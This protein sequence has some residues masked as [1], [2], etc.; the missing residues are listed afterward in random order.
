M[1]GRPADVRPRP[2]PAD[3]RHDATVSDPRTHSVEMTH[4]D[5]IAPVLAQA[6]MVLPRRQLHL[7]LRAVVNA[8]LAVH[9]DRVY[10]ACYPMLWPAA[11][12]LDVWGGE[13]FMN[14]VLIDSPEH[15]RPAPDG[16]DALAGR[17]ARAST[18][19]GRRAPAGGACGR[20]CPT[21]SGRRL[22]P[23]DGRTTGAP[24]PDR[25]PPPVQ[26][27]HSRRRPVRSSVVRRS[28]R[29]DPHH[30]TR[31]ARTN[32]PASSQHQRLSSGSVTPEH[33]K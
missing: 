26:L 1:R 8:G 6:L 17:G 20:T 10:L 15:V 33:C 2:G 25:R 5:L 14:K 13:R 29:P 21:V 24:V 22:P 30:A 4:N 11:D 31:V 32:G 27:A 12:A 9:E 16:P 18:A 7:K 3:A 23:A 28:A 19:A